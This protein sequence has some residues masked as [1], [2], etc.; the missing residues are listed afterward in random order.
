MPWHLNNK[1]VYDLNL[2][3]DFHLWIDTS[4]DFRLL[5]FAVLVLTSNDRWLCWNEKGVTILL[6]QKVKCHHSCTLVEEILDSFWLLQISFSNV[7]HESVGKLCEKKL[8]YHA[9]KILPYSYFK[10]KYFVGGWCKI[11]ITGL[12]I[13][14]LEKEMCLQSAVGHIPFFNQTIQLS[15]CT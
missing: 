1:H 7:K 4:L 5:L 8:L 3:L 10:P 15:S 9:L 12:T 11:K 2:S 6:I 14:Y 13:D